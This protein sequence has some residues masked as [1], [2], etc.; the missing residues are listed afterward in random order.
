[1][2][3]GAGLGDDPGLAHPPRQQD[4]AQHVVHLVAA[5]VVQ[6]FALE[7][8]RGAAQPFGQPLG[9]VKRRGAADVVDLQI[10]HLGGKG[11][12]GLRL[13]VFRL[14][15]ED[16]RHQSLAD[17]AAAEDAE[18]ALLVGAAHVAVQQ[19][20]GHRTLLSAGSERFLKPDMGR[21]KPEPVVEAVRVG[22]GGVG[23]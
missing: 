11:G 3:A 14:Q 23:G 4:L 18:A 22:A 20:V 2:L 10:L 19:I 15:V 17:E 9:L 13:L 6:L 7:I 8:H 5:G 16:Q 1:M 12:I 21:G